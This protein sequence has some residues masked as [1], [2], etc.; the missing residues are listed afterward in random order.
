M[1]A[2]EQEKDAGSRARF[3][4]RALELLTEA[5]EAGLK[6]PILDVALA[7]MH[8]SMGLA[9]AA[10]F[11]QSALA[12]RGLDGPDRC[13][14]LSL[15]ANDLVRAKNHAKAL[16]PLR[17]LTRWRRHPIDWLLL[18]DCEG[19]LGNAARAEEAMQ[20]AVRINPRLWG[21]HQHL[22]DYYRRQD[23]PNQAD[24]HQQRAVP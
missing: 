5:R 23:K 20:M 18:G 16:E 9:D 22:A 17:Q 4:K 15:W 6:D 13:N 2:A 11:A 7:R 14:A 21:V 8:L 10:S 12:Y 3:Q 1:E 19:S 24:W